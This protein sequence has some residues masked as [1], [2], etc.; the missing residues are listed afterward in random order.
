[1]NQYIIEHNASDIVK[2]TREGKSSYWI[3]KQLGCS[4]ISIR[5][6]LNKRGLQSKHKCKVD[7]SNLLKDR[8]E[9]VVQLYNNGMSQNSIAKKLGYSSSNIH[10]LLKKRGVK[11]RDW[12]Y[13]VN[14]EFF[15]R[16]DCEAKAYVLGWFY[17]YGCIDDG[18]KIRIQVSNSDSHILT[19]IADLLK[20]DGPLYDNGCLLCINR[21]SLAKKL[22]S[23]GCAPNKS[24]SLNF[25]SADII[26]RSLLSHFFRGVFDGHG[27]IIIK[28]GKYLN[29]TL[30]SNEDFIQSLREF[31]FFELNIDTKHYYR[32]SHTTTIQMMITRTSDA[33]KFLKW[34]YQD[35]TYY[36]TRNFLKYSRYLKKSV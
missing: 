27:S 13:Y 7:Y 12:R 34:L 2:W 35:A 21:K 16:I 19:T 15:D 17:F 20:Y 3:A 14:E 26:P 32:Y 30:V 28:S 31:L 11:I 25:P 22:I 1:V 10:R 6:F 18:G 4:G 5:Q 33:K 24:A 29:V 8:A 23:L 9:E 36:L